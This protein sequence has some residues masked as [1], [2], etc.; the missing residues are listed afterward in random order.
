MSFQKLAVAL[1]IIMFSCGKEESQAPSN[2]GVPNPDGPSN[3]DD[4]PG[5]NGI[6]GPP[7]NFEI[8]TIPIVAQ[9]QRI[10]SE[11]SATFSYDLQDDDLEVEIKIFGLLVEGDEY[12][13]ISSEWEGDVGKG[14]APG[15]NKTIQWT[16][17]QNENYIKIKVVA[18]DGQDRSIAHLVSLVSKQRI[19]NDLR[20]MTGVRHYRGGSTL[21]MQTRD[22]LEEQFRQCKLLVDRHSF[23]WQSTQGINIVGTHEGN[24][25]DFNDL[26]ITA[27]YDTVENTPGSDDNLSGT[28]G[29]LEAMRIL[30]QFEYDESIHFVGFDL[31]EV[32]LIGSRRYV[33]EIARNQNITAVINFEMIGYTCRSD[34]CSNLQLADTSIYNIGNSNSGVLRTAFKEHGN[35]YVPNLKIISVLADMNPNF[36]RSDHAPFWDA[37][38]PALFITDGANFRNPHYHQTTDS[39][40]TIDFEFATNI[41]KTTVATVASLAGIKTEGEAVIIVE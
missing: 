30:S 16:Q 6:I 29:M 27:H 14:I 3:S 4:S 34:I 20:E 31:E 11:G 35:A 12:I 17:A 7:H 32:G 22:Y 41:V 18:N 37:G 13:E 38:I 2:T 10:S 19:M 26:L 33:S 39:F 15:A 24:S 1:V 23:P 28:A 9:L 21:L 25:L 36:R 40:E 8:N 5:P